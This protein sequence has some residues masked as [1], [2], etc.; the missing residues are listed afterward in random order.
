MVSGDFVKEL[1]D[2]VQLVKSN[3]KAMKEFMT[4]QMALLEERMEGEQRG[5]AQGIKL[6]RTEGTESVAIKLIRRGRPLIE[7]HEDTGLPIQRLEQLANEN[8]DD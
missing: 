8:H 6:G 2:A 7:I 3:R 5:L 1:D 4:Y